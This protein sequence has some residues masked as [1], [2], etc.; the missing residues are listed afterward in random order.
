[1]AGELSKILDFLIPI[2][3]WA[4][5]I[6]VIYRVPIVKEGIDKLR[7]WWS[8]RREKDTGPETSTLRSINYE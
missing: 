7:N 5:L 3:V 6:Y 8:N 2:I 4:L 1:M